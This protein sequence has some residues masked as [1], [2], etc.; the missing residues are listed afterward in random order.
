MAVWVD[1]DVLYGPPPA[2][3]EPNPDG[4]LSQGLVLRGRVPGVLRK[5]G[6]AADGRW[7]GV[8]NFCICDRYS[9]T[10]AQQEMVVVPAEALTKQDPLPPRR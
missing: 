4:V 7:L 9:A 8:V 6:R 10:V 5:W 3:A 1:L 2:D